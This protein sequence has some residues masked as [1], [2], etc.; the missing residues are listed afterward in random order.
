MEMASDCPAL[1]SALLAVVH[2]TALRIETMAAFSALDSLP[3]RV[4][5]SFAIFPVFSVIVERKPLAISSLQKTPLN[6]RPFWRKNRR[7]TVN[8]SNFLCYSP[9]K[10]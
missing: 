4:R 5:G 2:K 8:I 10:T 1:P 6:M 7:P 9:T 3:E